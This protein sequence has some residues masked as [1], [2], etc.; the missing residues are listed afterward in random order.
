MT[1]QINKLQAEDTNNTLLRFKSGATGSMQ[2]TTAV[3]PKI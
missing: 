3:R 2:V 1:N